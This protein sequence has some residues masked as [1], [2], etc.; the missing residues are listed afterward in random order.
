MPKSRNL[1]FG[2]FTF[3]Y[4]FDYHHQ[5][6]IEKIAPKVGGKPKNVFMRGEKSQ[7]LR[8]GVVGVLLIYSLWYYKFIVFGT[9]NL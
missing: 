2:T 9:I 8:L 6:R 5:I 4:F 3:I 1:C 7:I